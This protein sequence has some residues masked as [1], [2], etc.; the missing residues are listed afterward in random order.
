MFGCIYVKV[1]LTINLSRGSQKL[2][3]LASGRNRIN[4]TLNHPNMIKSILQPVESPL[5]L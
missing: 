4:S 1:I 5:T 2:Q 3:I